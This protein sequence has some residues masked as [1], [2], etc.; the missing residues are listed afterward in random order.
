MS[1]LF[2]FPSQTE[3]ARLLSRQPDVD[4]TR[5][6]L[7]IAQDAYPSLAFEPTLQWIEKRA[8]ELGAPLARA[9][10]DRQLLA[11]FSRCLAGTH[12]LHGN[13]EAFQRAESSYLHRV[14]ETG[15]GIPISLSLVYMAV[16][17]EAG[18]DLSGIASPSHFL[19]R[20]EAADGP[21]FL[22]AF[23]AGEVMN[24]QQALSWLH[25]LSGLD[26]DLI[27]RSLNPAGPR[28]IVMRLLN[29]LKSVYVRNQTWEQ[30]WLVQRRL[31]ALQPVGYE[32]RRDLALVALKSGRAGQALDGL[33][34]CLRLCPADQR[35][36]LLSHLKAAEKLL[37]SFN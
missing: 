28:D 20:Y 3:F 36:L 5:V 37:A 13:R 33:Q 21:L 18:L 8:Q 19:T 11:E 12:G 2:D 29:N 22:D 30:A 32:S 17:R 1:P 24:H 10:T 23:H 9:R 34:E 25:S 35:P 14:V 26:F 7:E 31:T 27:E 15:V 16:A 6:A 4:L